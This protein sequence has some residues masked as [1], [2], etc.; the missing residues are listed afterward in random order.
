M[1]RKEP[2]LLGAVDCAGFSAR[3]SAFECRRF[4]GT[5]VVPQRFFIAFVSYFQGTRAMFFVPAGIG[6]P[7]IPQIGIYRP[8]VGRGLDPADHVTKCT[9]LDE[10][11]NVMFFRH[12]SGG[13]FGKNIIQ[14]TDQKP[15]P[16]RRGQDPALRNI[17]TNYNF[18]LSEIITFESTERN[19]FYG[20]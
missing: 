15:A 6:L 8:F 14:F 13:Y 9:R 4:A 12:V 2:P 1:Q 3:Y 19:D 16:G 7:T 18:P 17:P 20:L 11:D 10:W 5:R